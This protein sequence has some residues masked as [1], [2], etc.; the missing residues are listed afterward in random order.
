MK[1]IT[2]EKIADVRQAVRKAYV[3]YPKND[4]TVDKMIE[5]A[6]RTGYILGLNDR[7]VGGSN[8]LLGY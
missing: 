1:K 2:E 5:Q 4:A 7:E 6:V 3:E 8:G